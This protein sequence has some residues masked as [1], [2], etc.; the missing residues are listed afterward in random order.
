MNATKRL[1]GIIS[2]LVIAL[3]IISSMS[4]VSCASQSSETSKVPSH[5]TSDIEMADGTA[6]A[7]EQNGTNAPAEHMFIFNE[8]GEHIPMSIDIDSF[9]EV[10]NVVYYGKD[11]DACFY[12]FFTPMHKY[13]WVY[14]DKDTRKVWKIVEYTDLISLTADLGYDDFDYS[15]EAITKLYQES[16]VRNYFKNRYTKDYGKALEPYSS[17]LECIDLGYGMVIFDMDED[18]GPVA[19]TVD[20]SNSNDYEKLNDVR[21]GL[22]ASK[23]KIEDFF[24]A[25]D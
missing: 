13:Y 5:V 8:E 23:L 10:M 20:K 4:T 21:Y 16:K 17:S 22:K 6:E 24:P 18:L 11:E 1:G 3:F 12:S 2:V 14:Y 7:R 9:E 25:I 15:D 19:I